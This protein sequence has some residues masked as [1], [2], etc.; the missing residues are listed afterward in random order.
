MRVMICLGQGGLRSLSAS[1]IVNT[2]RDI[3]CI[4]MRSAI[5]LWEPFST[6]FPIP[7]LPFFYRDFIPR[8]DM[9]GIHSKILNTRKY[10]VYIV[11]IHIG[12]RFTYTL[13][14]RYLAAISLFMASMESY[15]HK[16][17]WFMPI[18]IYI[19][20]NYEYKLSPCVLR[21]FK[22]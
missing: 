6:L 12:K 15:F 9:R 16:R 13:L 11:I 1:S 21:M 8:L 2:M 18:R 19:S 7:S 20:V 10:Y 3:L 14:S 22:P 5:V 4:W 17:L